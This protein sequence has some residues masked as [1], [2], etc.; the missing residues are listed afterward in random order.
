MRLA[1]ATLWILTG[2]ALTA[3]V[4]WGFLS[5]PESTVGT[6]IVS[7]IL[8]A[9]ALAMAG[10][11]ASGA[12]TIW[13]HGASLAGIGRAMR[14]SLGVI[15][16]ALLI[17]LVWWV[18]ERAETWIAMRSGQIS[19]IF[20]ARFGIADISRLFT[21][22]HYIA[23]WFRWAVS[24]LMALSLMAGIAGIGWA[25]LGQAAWLRRALHPR[26]LIVATF[27]FV[28]LIALPWIYLVPWRPKGIPAS[29]VEF[30]FIVAK[31][32]V[33]AILFAIG[34]ALIV[35]EASRLPKPPAMAA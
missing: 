12:I 8:A 32:S 35:N 21:A 34:A 23:N 2:S 5:T 25:A 10:V 14:S 27:W 22:T 26:A 7:A 31:L 24:P 30:A 6:L 33:T 1:L 16:A 28:V 17:L 11:T 29:S 20:I 15:P 3:G 9:I 19:A 13:S 4:Y 18:A